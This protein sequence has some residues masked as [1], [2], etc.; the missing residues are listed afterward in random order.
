MNDLNIPGWAIFTFIPLIVSVV[1]WL[2]SLQKAVNKNEQMI[3]INTANDQQVGDELKRINRS[4][5]EVKS[6]LKD[7]FDKSFD[8]LERR[9]DTF[10][11]QEMTMLKTMVGGK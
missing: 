8:K 7:S 10:I 1:G 6:E 4:V 11:S 3:A 9:L 2:W 5:N